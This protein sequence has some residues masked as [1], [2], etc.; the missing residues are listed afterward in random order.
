MARNTLM[1]G[2]TFAHLLG[3]SR[4]SSKA[5]AGKVRADADDDK[6]DRRDEEDE[7]DEQ[8]RKEDDADKQKRRRDEDE[9]DERDEDEDD[10]RDKGDTKA[11]A[12]RGRERARCAAIF[13]H[14]AATGRPDFAA[15]L[16]F[17]TNLGRRAACAMLKSAA[18]G[19]QSQPGQDRAALPSGSKAADA[20]W[21]AAAKRT[22][23]RR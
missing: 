22:G 5:K 11:S 21:D 2:T 9:D 7:Q 20:S 18:S 23:V 10:T 14:S 8:R 1:G 16:A 15:H 3:F 19:G 12:A 17:E 4:G 6:Q 13:K